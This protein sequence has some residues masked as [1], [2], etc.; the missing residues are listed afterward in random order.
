MGGRCSCAFSKGTGS[1][2]SPSPTR[3]V[4]QKKIVRFPLNEP[5][6][7][8]AAALGPGKGSGAQGSSP[9]PGPCRSR[10]PARGPRR[11]RNVR[12]TFKSSPGKG[13]GPDPDFW[14]GREGG[15]FCLVFGAALEL[16]FEKRERKRK[17]EGKKKRRGGRKGQGKRR[18]K[19]TRTRW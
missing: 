7:C 4:V 2:Q 18:R 13:N 3:L 6:F 15:L 16:G 8:F 11:P 1:L 14:R 19:R 10:S 9:A 12:R 17:R 5:R